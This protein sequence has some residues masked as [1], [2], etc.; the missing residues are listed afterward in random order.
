MN[1]ISRVPVLRLELIICV[2]LSKVPPCMNIF[3]FWIIR[4][5]ALLI[6]EISVSPQA[7]KLEDYDGNLEWDY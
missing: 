2:N 4:E 1:L 7:A 5:L 6:V 3:F